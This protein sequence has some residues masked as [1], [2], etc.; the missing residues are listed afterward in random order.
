M[1][2]IVLLT[3]SLL[4][5]IL[6]NAQTVTDTSKNK[7]DSIQTQCQELIIE[8]QQMHN[9]LKDQLIELK[10]LLEE[11]KKKRRK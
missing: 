8:Q 9:E 7:K 4:L 10:T 3:S 5:I 11:K 1:N 6:T 2:T